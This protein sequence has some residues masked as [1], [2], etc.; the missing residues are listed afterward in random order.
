MIQLPDNTVIL[1]FGTFNPVHVG[2]M[3]IGQYMLEHTSAKELWYVVTPHNPFKKQSNLLPDR[4]RLQV[5][6]G[7]GGENPTRHQMKDLGL[8]PQ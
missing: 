4:Q 1:Y 8:L 2:H 6:F 5:T 3:I 7:T